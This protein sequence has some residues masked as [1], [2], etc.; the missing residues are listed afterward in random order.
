MAPNSNLAPQRTPDY[1]MLDHSASRTAAKEAALLSSLTLPS[2]S[3]KVI[4]AARSKPSNASQCFYAYHTLRTSKARL[5][6]RRPFPFTGHTKVLATP[7]SHANR[8][9]YQ[10]PRG[11]RKRKVLTFDRVTCIPMHVIRAQK[12]DTSALLRPLPRRSDELKKLVKIRIDREMEK[13]GD[14]SRGI[15]DAAFW[16]PRKPKL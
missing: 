7:I 4:P 15:L 10:S 12:D 13:L 16:V 8:E 1:N 2:P 3:A 9:T 6:Y 5:S 11:A 14:V